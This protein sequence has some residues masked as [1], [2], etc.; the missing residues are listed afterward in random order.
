MRSRHRWHRVG[1]TVDSHLYV[2]SPICSI[3][4]SIA[5]RKSF[6][7]YVQSPTNICSTLAPARA[8][9]LNIYVVRGYCVCVC[10]RVGGVGGKERGGGEAAL[11]LVV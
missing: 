7:L 8:P 5:I 2:Q 9:E 4:K 10:A 1:T 6:H 3:L 11:R